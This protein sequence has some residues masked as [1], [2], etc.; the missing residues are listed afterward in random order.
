[1]WAVEV[2]LAIA[3]ARVAKRNFAAGLSGSLEESL[4]RAR[5]SDMRNARDVLDHRLE[6]QEI[7]VSREDEGWRSGEMDVEQPEEEV[8]GRIERMDS[9]AMLAADGAG[10]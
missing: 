6:V 2:P 5:E 10:W 7:V 3:E 4:R 8:K 1:V 9:I